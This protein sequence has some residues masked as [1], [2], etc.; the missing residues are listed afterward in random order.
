MNTNL[1]PSEVAS[2]VGVLDPE[3]IAAGT[4][5]T[6]WIDAKNA[7]WF[8]AIIQTGVLGAASPAATIDAKIEQAQDGSGTGAKD[9][10]GKAIT[11]LVKATGDDKQAIIQINQDDL[12]KEVI[13]SSPVAA[14]TH[15]R[16][17]LTVANQ[18]SLASALVMAFG[19]KEYPASDFDLASVAEIVG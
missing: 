16:L 17:S 2:I 14:F 13:G 4:V 9:V 15:F 5:E 3:S 11:Q 19:P 7:S 12:D 10:T 1:R 18:A 8:M 6:P